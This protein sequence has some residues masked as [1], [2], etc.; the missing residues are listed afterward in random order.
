MPTGY[1]AMQTF[2]SNGFNILNDRIIKTYTS[3]NP[4]SLIDMILGFRKTASDKEYTVIEKGVPTRR[5]VW[6]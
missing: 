6:F 1:K 3:S 2:Q 4:E 5:P